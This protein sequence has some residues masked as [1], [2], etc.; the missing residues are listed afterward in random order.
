MAG[1][2]KGI[3]LE[4]GG[5][6]T[7]LTQALKEPQKESMALRSKLKDVNTALKFDT[8]NVDLLN[9]KQELI[10]KSISS[11]EAELKLLRQAQEQYKASG[12]D[13]NSDEYI[14]LEKK[15]ALA[16]RSLEKLKEQQNNF[17]GGVQAMGK[18]M[19]E[20]GSKSE[21]AGK[22][23]LPVTASLT[24]VALGSVAAFNE[25]DEGYDTI[26]TKTG[27]TGEAAENLQKSM[28]NVFSDLPTSAA[29]AG[30]AIGEVNTRFGLTGDSLESLS[31]QFIQFAQ[32]NETDLNASIGSVNKNL[33]VFGL[34]ADDAQ[35]YLGL[36]T[37][38]AQ[39][40]GISVDDLMA[41]VQ[42]NGPVFK[43][44]GLSID[45]SVNLLAQ[46]E[47]N[48]VNA[49]SALVGLRKAQQNATAEGK[50]LNDAL[51]ESITAIKGAGS[52]TEALQIATELFGKKG[53][54]E[55]TQAIREGRFSVEDLSSSLGDFKD[56]VTNTFEGTQ[57][58]PDKLA[59]TMN[60]L[61]LAG[62]E[63]GGSL[64]E[65]LAPAFEKL[66]DVARKVAEWFSSLS[67]GQQR[68]I[69]VVGGLVAAIGP[70]LIFIGKMSTGLSVL[71]K[72]FG[73][74]E[75]MGGK[76]IASF[77]SLAGG[78]TIGAGAIAGIVAAVAALVGAFFTLW[79]SNE[80]FR[81]NMINTW[82]DIVG[83]IQEF[84][85]GITDRINELGFDFE[86][87]T[88]VIRTVW[89][90]FCD[91]LAPV[92]E[93]VWS[94]ISTT[95]GTALNHIMGIVDFF[96]SLFKGDWQGCWDAVSS[97]ASGIWEGIIGVFN[98]VLETLK[99]ALN[100]VLGWFGTSWEECWGNI[101]TFFTDIWNNI[102]TVFTDTWNAIT[103]F[104]TDVWNG[105]STTCTNVWNG[106]S[107]FI[108][109]LLDGINTTFSNIWNGISTFVSDT[110]NGI[111]TTCTDVWNN[112]KKAITDPIDKAKETLS[113]TIE[114]I[115][116]KCSSVFDGV[117]NKATEVWNNVKTA[118]TDPIDKAKKAVGDAIDNIKGFFN[119]QFH[120]PNLPLPH[121]AINPKG[122]SI[123][124]LLKG[125]IPTLGID[126]YA[127]AMDAGQILTGPTI[128]GMDQDGRLL[129]GGEAGAE[130]VV[131]VSS[132][133]Q[134]I[135]N[136][137]DR[138]ASRYIRPASQHST[139]VVEQDL[140]YGRLAD[141]LAVSLTGVSVHNTVNV[142]G[143]RVV[144]ELLPLID[145]GLA[146]RSKRR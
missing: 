27:A 67:D 18:K 62:K 7:K 20:F 130:A 36:L 138:A 12:K 99:N 61:K 103:T 133:R 144:D 74:T 1:N 116:T 84:F 95:I 48:G 3:T 112:I 139:V 26:I 97:I 68:M 23:L 125:K 13:L 70:L 24:A 102:S 83:K 39:A 64:L 2:I 137:V 78:C 111:K 121:F 63:L 108:G 4:I 145:R 21:K 8:K 50:T 124:D 41:S 80:E 88:D 51:G 106:V 17:N 123:G 113:T 40:T 54:L 46:F 69:L 87:I 42:K 19:E 28:D 96:I 81:T 107:E 146:K 16:E 93:G 10:T 55:M 79:N 22:A 114:G 135:M 115:K 33:Q 29:E 77:R 58:P 47:K 82:N 14:A 127:K 56:T 44:M 31:K 45:E 75:T 105:I 131:G 71:V 126:W 65:A 49:D 104:V 117:K 136:A 94:I 57:D 89:Q 86:N 109:G 34:G 91:F 98:T 72:Y 100:V 129:A 38:Q 140:D 128:F 122:W 118:I 6:S 52:E 37:S 25:I 92:F 35:G 132:L 43:E 90:G 142:G 119:F 53:A 120:W 143:Q 101:S 60:N 30:T 110:W 59:T 11:T 66:A 76:L 141:A 32:I 5:D 9:Q 15:I 73:S 134:M 85:Q